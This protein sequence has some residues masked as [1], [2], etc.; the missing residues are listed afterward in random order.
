MRLD[1]KTKK[2]SRAVKAQRGGGGD[3]HSF[4]MPTAVSIS[5]GC[6]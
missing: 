5:R 6:L 4:R 3:A 2:S 1:S